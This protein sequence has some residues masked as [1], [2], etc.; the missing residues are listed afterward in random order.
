MRYFFDVRSNTCTEHDHVGQ[1]LV[2][3]R[4]AQEMAELIAT[5]LGCTRSDKPMEMKVEIRSCDGLLISTV[6][7]KMLDA[8]AA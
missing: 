8:E 1:E 2:T 4:D 6:P 5:D 7:V 3:L